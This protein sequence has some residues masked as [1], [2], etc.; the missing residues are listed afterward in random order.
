MNTAGRGGGDEAAFLFSLTL[1]EW[2]GAV[3][4]AGTTRSDADLQARADFVVQRVV[5]DHRDCE[6]ILQ[7]RLRTLGVADVAELRAL[8]SRAPCRP[9]WPGGL[10]YVAWLVEACAVP[11]READAASD[12]GGLRSVLAPLV[13]RARRDA[14][15]IIAATLCGDDAAF[16]AGVCT[17]AMREVPR[18]IVRLV[19]APFVLEMHLAGGAARKDGFAAAV[20]ALC[21]VPGALLRFLSTYPALARLL[22]ARLR[23]W[24]EHCAE[25]S[26]RMAQDRPLLEAWL[27]RPLRVTAVETGHGDEHAGG[28]SVTRVWAGGISFAYK[29]RSL[30]GAAALAHFCDA[31]QRLDRGLPTV[32]LPRALD[33]GD[34]GWVEWLE[35][36]PTT[37]SAALRRYYR[38]LGHLLALGWALG[39][40]DMHSE[41]IVAVGDR[42]YL[43]DAETVMTPPRRSLRDAQ[44]VAVLEATPLSTGI[45][46]MRFWQTGEAADVDCSAFGDYEGQEATFDLPSW[47]AEGTSA[48]RMAPA[49]P[50]RSAPKSQPR[51]ADGAVV[52]SGPYAGE[53]LSGFST[54]MHA[55]QHNGDAL[56]GAGSPL[57]EF[58]G[59]RLRAVLRTTAEYAMRLL[60]GLHTD[61]LG[62]ALLRE[63]HFDALRRAADQ[64]GSD[65]I[66]E[67]EVEDMLAGDIPVFFVDADSTT[68]ITGRGVRMPEYFRATSLQVA[69]QRLATLDRERVEALRWSVAASLGGRELNRAHAIPVA[70]CC[71]RPARDDVSDQLLLDA[72][73]AI[74][75]R[76]ASLLHR[77]GAGGAS[78]LDLLSTGGRRWRVV[79]ADRNLYHGVAGMAL[80]FDV[81][82]S[83]TDDG[84]MR[85]VAEMLRES[86]LAM[87]ES[88]DATL[89]AIGLDGCGGVLYV[90]SFLQSSLPDRR[91]VALIAEMVQRLE[92]P[93]SAAVG[94]DVISGHAG[95]ILG[96]LAGAGSENVI[97]A[98][99]VAAALQHGAALAAAAVREPEGAAWADEEGR[100]RVGFAHGSAGIAYALR[101]LSA[102]GGDDARCLGVLAGDAERWEDSRYREAIGNWLDDAAGSARMV[103]RGGAVASATWCNGSAGIGFARAL[104]LLCG[105]GADRREDLGVLQGGLR[106]ALRSAL[107]DGLGYGMSLCHG[108][109]S[110][111][112]LCLAGAEALHDDDLCQRA[113]GIAGMVARRVLR[114]GGRAVTG[115]VH[116]TELPGLFN[117][118]AGVGYELLRVMAPTAVPS[119]L[120]MQP[121]AVPVSPGVGIA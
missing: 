82:A 59:V 64:V 18:R 24:A 38:R 103:D 7:S 92:E 94:N 100:L 11:S 88:D 117:G 53:V 104:S 51:G 116:C 23:R 41:N 79:T 6:T 3:R 4:C 5:A 22:E 40:C 106:R 114:Q 96:L 75:G 93:A 98:R 45:L 10:A 112:E 42:P 25:M 8:L 30:A 119:V 95:A 39:S 102:I 84:S 118:S 109:M 58:R 56:L 111:V 108:D 101:R 21:T 20:A 52:D 47:T 57:G 49:R 76:L 29:P 120:A 48:M 33:R 97:A 35:A 43:I 2:V 54:A 107:K 86:W 28:R 46:P 63:L 16:A 34:Y 69:H 37:N 66:A 1:A 68:L 31:L 55:L 121:V 17:V 83:T 85:S 44:A 70:R 115:T 73:L 50:A 81:L 89:G 13:A 9:P 110:V 87:Q 14:R 61:L 113:R 19:T 77:D 26:V 72:A 99:A 90:A 65:V 62:D 71:R 36:A 32:Y 27:S 78:Y 12:D 91:L 67:E 74:G 15:R 105:D 80:F 60:D